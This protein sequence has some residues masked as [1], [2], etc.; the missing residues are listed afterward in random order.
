M[1]TTLRHLK[2]WKRRGSAGTGD[3]R[4]AGVRASAGTTGSPMFRSPSSDSG[5]SDVQTAVA[6]RSV[7]HVD[8]TATAAQPDPGALPSLVELLPPSRGGVDRPSICVT[9]PTS[10]PTQPPLPPPPC[11]VDVR[12]RGGGVDATVPPR[13]RRSPSAAAGGTDRLLT[14]SE[15]R[16]TGVCVLRCQQEMVS[17]ETFFDFVKRRDVDSIQYALRDAHYDIDS[18]DAVSQL[19]F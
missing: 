10:S 3:G 13:G 4:G 7:V 17:V 6:V 18:Q 12:R 1:I 11:V 8:A 15:H 9:A 19:R 14:V 2:L 16:S 5:Y